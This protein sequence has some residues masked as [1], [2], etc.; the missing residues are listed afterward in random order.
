MQVEALGNGEREGFLV[1]GESEEVGDHGDFVV[2]QLKDVGEAEG[3][4]DDFA[5][6]EV[7]AEIHVEDTQAVRRGVLEE[8]TDGATA[9]RGALGQGTEADCLALAGQQGER[10]IPRDVIP[11]RVG[12][13]D[14]ARLLGGVEG[15]R[16]RAGRVIVALEEQG[17]DVLIRKGG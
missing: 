9:D 6:V 10:L 3:G 7:L 15:H 2:V 8:L 1:L 16:D 5:R 11:G 14:V 13:E 4:L 12:G 17:V